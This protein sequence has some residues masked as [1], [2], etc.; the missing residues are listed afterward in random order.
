MFTSTKLYKRSASWITFFFAVSVL[1]ACE[2]PKEETDPKDPC[3]DKKSSS[4]DSKDK[5]DAGNGN[6][7]PPTTP[8]TTPPKPYPFPSLPN[9]V[10]TVDK[11]KQDQTTGGGIKK[12]DVLF[13]MDHSGSMADDWERVANNLQEMVKELPADLNIRYA[14]L[15]SD[16]GNM[17]GRLY[18][19]AGYKVVLDNQKMKTQE[20]SNN[21]HKMFVEG[22]KVGDPTG[23]AAFYSLHKAATA[24]AVDNQRLGF[25]RADAALSVI[26]A[27]DEQ[28]AGFP[29]PNPQAPGLPQRCDTDYEES[30]KKTYYDKQGVNLDVAFNAVKKLKGDMP[31]VTHAFVNIT[32]E[33]LFKRNSKNASC[34]YDSL[35]YGY[36]EMVAKTQGVLFSIQ[37]NRAEGMARCGQVTRE[38]LQIVHDFKLSKPAEK[39]DPVTI[40]AGV[41]GALAVHS[42]K[43]VENMV[44]LDNAGVG[45]SVVEIRHCEPDGRKA[46]T[47]VDFAGQ[48]AQYSVSLGWKTPEYA[49]DGKVLYG[50]AANALT[51]ASALA[52]VTTDHAVVV[53]GLTP[54]TVYYFQGVSKDEFGQEKKSAVISL[55]TLPDW[56]ITGVNGQ[57]SRNTATVKWRTAEYP[58]K[59]KVRYGVDGNA[60][61]NESAET[62]VENDH[63]VA[64]A[65]LQ[66]NTTYFYQV[67]SKDEYGL[68]KLGA[69]ANMRTVTDWGII[70]FAGQATR[71]SVELAWQ[72]PEYD[73]NGKVLWGTSP[74]NIV[75]QAGSGAVG[76][77]HGATVI[78][79]A[80]NTVYYFQAVGSDDLG[81][82]KRS[83]VI[84][85]RTLVDWTIANFAGTSTVDAV[86][87]AWETAEY[88]TNGKVLWG[89]AA[90][91]LTNAQGDG[92]TGNA[93]AVTIGGLN[94]DTI[95][96]FQAVS[97]D[98]INVEKRSA[99]IA[100]RTQKKPVIPPPLPVW[101]ISDFGGLATETTVALTWKTDGYATSGK[102][103][104]SATS[105]ALTNEVAEAGAGFAHSVN[106]SGL[107]ADTIY[108]FQVVAYDDKGQE[109]QSAEIPVRTLARQP[110]PNPNPNPDPNPNPNPNPIPSWS[111]MGFD[112]TTTA[113]SATMI[114]QTPGVQTKAT[115]KIGLSPTDLT[116]QAI[117]VDNAAEAQLVPVSGLSANT[118]YYFQVIAV[119]ANGTT[120][121][122]IVI[123]KRTKAQ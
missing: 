23:E 21:L 61:V 15:L 43:A 68:E 83:N 96:Y 2:P 79:L 10:C 85:V 14:V 24:N 92:V 72:T 54:N 65:N 55:R 28:E 58:T 86:N 6:P 31:L 120:H 105:G 57:A 123:M 63:N 69:V 104:W 113:R 5:C 103:R 25:F 16:V 64:L 78:G 66:A 20:I 34:L 53:A 118:A 67:V 17:A 62:A 117:A 109:K 13:V 42:Y 91:A 101:D 12:L 97:R 36:F 18:A 8:P 9:R 90:D 45:G 52:P 119:D 33:D 106:V 102:V 93:H 3:K 84:A 111:V 107:N 81:S 114:W 48:A 30:I 35:G 94:E 121:E 50:L 32:K 110:D 41:D 87:V 112:G 99:V 122:S 70:G 44:H 77:S 46:W 71:T 116:L 40:I 19:P 51:S 74:N 100:I 49:T 27:S 98:D 82:E 7:K 88:A 4:Q 59:G 37:A 108:Y 89:L 115:L 39:V 26:F 60:L 38:R 11:F 95:Y 80:P 76:R 29:F 47:L 73:T 22:M 75:N 1:T 56:N